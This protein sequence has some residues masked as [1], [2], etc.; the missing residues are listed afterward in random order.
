MYE[1]RRMTSEQRVLKLRQAQRRPWHSP[2]HLDL[3][4]DLQYL[5]TAACY[6]HEGVIGKNPAR[7]AECEDELL[8][9]MHELCSVTYAWCVLP[10]HYHLLLKTERIKDLRQALALFHGRSS[11]R[12]NGEDT[13]RGRKVWFN[14]F[15][16]PMKSE[17]HLWASLN[18]VHHN[19]VHHGY[20]AHWQDW[21]WSSAADFLRQLGREKAEAIWRKYPILEYGKK[22]DVY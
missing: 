9:L 16:R 6:E 22:W 13:A 5:V 12:W 19:P 7:M 11:Y 17:R 21:P 20:L 3:E 1:W 4:F 14:C 8:K 15:E 10:D 2:P 18:Y